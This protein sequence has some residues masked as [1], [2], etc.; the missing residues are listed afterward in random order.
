M[1]ETRSGAPRLQVLRALLAETMLRDRR[2]LQR[3]LDRLGAAQTPDDAA[4]AAWQRRADSARERYS[5]RAARAPAIAVD[6]SLPIAARG[7]DI[8]ALIRKHPVIVLAGETGSGKSTQLPKLCLAAGRGLSGLIGCTQPRRVAARNVARRVASELGTQVGGLVGFQVRFTEQVGEQTLIKFMTDGILLAETQSD[9]WLD[10]Y[11]TIILDEAHE[12]SLNIDFLLGFLKRLLERR[13]DLKLIVTSATI[14]TAR[15][16]R[17]F[18]DAP[19]VEV[20]GRSFPVEV[21]WRPIEA[22]AAARGTD[23]PSPAQRGKVAEG[24]KGAG[25]EVRAARAD[26]GPI[27]HIVAALDEITREDPRGDALVFLPGEREIRDVHLALE[28][29]KY[30][31]TEVLPLYARLS[32]NEQDRVFKPG[33]A[34]RIVLATNVAETSLTVPRIRYVIDT[35][36]A[37]VKR[38]SQRNQ[39]ERLH[40]EPIAQAA[41]DQRK[42]RCGRIG[43]GICVRLYGEEDFASRPRFA[44]PEIMRSSLG[45]VILRMLALKLGDVEKFPFVEA[46]SARAIGD[47]YRRLAELGAIDDQRRLTDTGRMMA[48]VPID[49]ALARMLIEAQRLGALR[50]ILIVTSF[51]S[52]QDPRERPADA[53]AAADAAHAAFADTKSDFVSILNLWHAHSL[54]H[55]ELTQSKMRDWCSAR[56]LSYLRMREWREL[57]RQLLVMADE[58]GWSD[59]ATPSPTSLAMGERAGVRGQRPHGAKT[60]RQTGAPPPHPTLS[61]NEAAVGGEGLSAHNYE[62]IHRSLLSGWPTQVG[63]KEERNVYRGTR[64][65]KFQI[66]PGSGQAKLTPQWLLS[67]QILDLQKVYAMLC[68]RIE[69][70]W[71][72]QQAAHLVKRSWRDAHWSRKRGAVLAF[73][74]VTLFGLTLVEKRS[75]QFGSQDPNLAHEVFLREALTRGDLDSRADCVRANIRVLEQAHELEAKRRRAGLVKDEDALVGFFRGKLPVEINTVAAFD[76]WYRKA[77][78]PEQAALHWSL[79]FVLASEPGLRASDFPTRLDIPG[80]ALRLEYRFVPGDPADGVTLQVPL[81]FVNAVPVARCQWLV[82]GLLPDKVAELIRGLPKSLRRNFVPAP[83]FARAFAQAEAPRDEPLS[84]VLAAYLKRVTGVDVASADFAD[85]PVPAHLSMRFRIHDERGQT[86]AEGRDLA[87]IRRDWSAQ[88]N[89][90]FSRRTD[91]ELAREDVVEFEFDEIP[92]Q[93]TAAG[94]L[95]AFPALVDLGESVALRVFERADEARAAHARGVERLLRRALRDRIKQARRQL[96]IDRRLAL[97]YAAIASVDSLREDLVEAALAELLATGDL[98][99]RRR[100]A[101]RALESA[102]GQQLFPAAVAWL[103]LV[104]EILAAYAELTP[105]LEPPLMGY[106]RANYDDLREQLDALVFPGFVSKVDK[107]HLAH[108]PRYLRAMRLRAERLRQDATRDQARMLTVRSYWREYLKLRAGNG[109]SDDA[110]LD[111]LRWMIEELRVSLFAQELKTAE[112]VSPKRLGKLI[113][114]LGA[115]R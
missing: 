83:D 9:P 20:E 55:E 8:V 32:A 75:V 1:N 79:D 88:A 51:L 101:F 54:A 16:A 95:A 104:E 14:D 110:A 28:R 27:E 45:G 97:K 11:D 61:P 90:A 78:A 40:I 39:L 38:Y 30:R 72:E 102:L 80:H 64:E 86:L 47:G 17:H 37:R 58:Y 112:P 42:G 29:R 23:F 44:D 13:R 49:V 73:E 63:I 52:I 76:A 70:A 107:L 114:V 31:H 35:G 3:E 91:A 36:T 108:Y 53:R 65:R 93:L 5:A 25:A 94:G 89:A 12:R 87:A 26:L 10:A 46:P 113:E 84:R 96:P 85:V 71:I 33:S 115:T 57:H 15:F 22:Y 43:P 92:E 50:E 56:F 99:V 109:E 2:R 34:R 6:D 21:R 81:A 4:M 68:A 111:E 67:G 66:F 7:D 100:E 48:R 60:H 105:W 18:N 82:P 59:I 62:A 106:A 98:Q 19:V 24:R 103:T 74:Q 69:P 41:A 77:S